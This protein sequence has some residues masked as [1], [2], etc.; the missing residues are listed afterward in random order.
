MISSLFL[1]FTFDKV[2]LTSLTIFSIFFTLFCAAW[3]IV[4]AYRAP[5]NVARPAFL[6][7]GFSH[8]LFQWPIALFSDLLSAELRDFYL[9]SGAIH[10]AVVGSCYWVWR[11]PGLTV[12]LAH[13]NG[14]NTA[15]DGIGTPVLLTLVGIFVLL[16][17]VY[18][19]SIEPQCTALYALIFDAASGLLARETAG[20]I[21]GAG[22]PSYIYGILYNAV[23]PLLLLCCV[24]EIRRALAGWK[25]FKAIALLGVAAVAIFA[26]LLTGT[27]G[28]IVPTA[29]GVTVGILA[30]GASTL[31]GRAIL[32]A[33]CGLVALLVISGFDTFVNRQADSNGCYPVGACAVRSRTCEPTKAL[34]ASLWA[35]DRSLGLERERLTMIEA[36]LLEHCADV[37][38]PAPELI[39]RPSSH[40][41]TV[42]QMR[43][44]ILAQKASP[45][46]P[47]PS[48]SPPKAEKAEEVKPKDVEA[49]SSIASEQL[50]PAAPQP[51]SP[52]LAPD[53]ATPP[54]PPA[55]PPV[56]V[57]QA[58]AA[59]PPADRKSV[60]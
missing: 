23:C 21:F 9:M 20:K 54:P 5:H 44:L 34:I 55:A 53:A 19:V 50:A 52:A 51:P 56:A 30:S 2:N 39:C 14:S 28:N 32:V 27:K 57:P 41:L 26:T 16:A 17:T 11:T 45:P 31:I 4:I 47:V 43:E 48:V 58:P 1:P 35:R 49:K 18:I 3:L 36:D 38:K 22:A 29:V 6:V 59:P 46:T 7:A 10:C 37:S 8:L 13:G 15:D 24:V 60:V 25:I 12:R 42:K 33:I 40:P